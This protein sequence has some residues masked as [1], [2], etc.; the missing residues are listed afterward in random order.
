MWLHIP[1][2]TYKAYPIC[3]ITRVVV[4]LNNAVPKKATFGFVRSSEIAFMILCK[5]RLLSP[6]VVSFLS[7]RWGRCMQGNGN[8]IRLFRRGCI[9]LGLDVSWETR[10]GS[11]EK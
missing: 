7:R 4:L 1:K 10:E 6:I 9:Y 11:V 3:Y 8:G 2:V 5:F